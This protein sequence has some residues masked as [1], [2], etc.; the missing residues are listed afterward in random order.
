MFESVRELYQKHWANRYLGWFLMGQPVL[1]I[2]DPKLLR[3]VMVKDFSS[4]VERSSYDSDILKLGGKYDKLLGMQ[5]T[6]AHESPRLA[7]RG[8]LGN[9]T[10]EGGGRF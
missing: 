5:L 10:K 4:F 3:V 6:G 9:R 7:C 1:N 8:A 2:V